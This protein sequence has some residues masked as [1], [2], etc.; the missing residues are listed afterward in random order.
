MKKNN[1]YTY[2]LEIFKHDIPINAETYRGDTFS[3]PFHQD[4][5]WDSEEGKILP[6][7][8]Y[9]RNKK[10]KERKSKIEKIKKNL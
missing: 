8:D 3:P 5:I 9:V 6:I 7:S 10:I 1:K 2:D 4:L